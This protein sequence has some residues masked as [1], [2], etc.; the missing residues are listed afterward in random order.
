MKIKKRKKNARRSIWNKTKQ[1]VVSLTAALIS[2]AT[3]GAEDVGVTDVPAITQNRSQRK[4]F[5][6]PRRGDTMPESETHTWR[7]LSFINHIV[8][9]YGG[10][11]HDLEFPV[12]DF[13]FSLEEFRDKILAKLDDNK[14]FGD[15]ITKRTQARC[16]NCMALLML[17]PV[18]A[19]DTC[20]RCD[21]LLQVVQDS[22]PNRDITYLK[23][24]KVST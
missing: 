6:D 10:S 9:T 11:F 14:A 1:T 16:P 5:P 13:E 17:G 3:K 21:T 7:G 23:F 12:E 4:T 24:I 18:N 15:Q 8:K 20:A 2:G 22:I 19:R